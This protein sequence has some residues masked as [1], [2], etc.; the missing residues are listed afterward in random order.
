VFKGFGDGCP[1]V[2]DAR[3]QA[4][5]MVTLHGLCFEHLLVAE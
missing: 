5:E 4:P 3:G 2:F 1:E